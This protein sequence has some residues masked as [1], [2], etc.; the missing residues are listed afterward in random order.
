MIEGAG[1]GLYSTGYV[2]AGSVIV[3]P[4]KIQ[5]TARIEELE[6]EELAV[7]AHSSI[8]WF[9]N[10][11]TLAPDWPDEC[12]VNHSFSPNG[13]WHLGFIFALADILPDTEITVDYRYLLAPDHKMDFCDA[14]TGRE[15]IGLPWQLA[16]AQSAQ[17][18]AQIAKRQMQRA[19][20]AA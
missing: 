12:Y 9:E 14:A 6:G 2:P 1:Q 17:T 10:I 5:H 13:L 18:L 16:L 3:A 7:H 19:S 4:D 11:C 8:R 15:I 20:S